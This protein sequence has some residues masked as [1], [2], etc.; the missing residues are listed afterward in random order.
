[1][2]SYLFEPQI[3]DDPTVGREDDNPWSSIRLTERRERNNEMNTGMRVGLVS[4]G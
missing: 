1:M 2:K 4:K 3:S